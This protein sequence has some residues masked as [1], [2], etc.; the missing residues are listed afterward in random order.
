MTTIPLSNNASGPQLAAK[1][2]TSNSFALNP[3]DFIKMMITQLQNQDPLQPTSN[4]QLLSQMS[5]IGQMQSASSLQ[6]TLS[7]LAQ[8][9][10]IGAASSLIGKTVQGTDVNDNPLSGLV[11]S[12]K[13]ASSGISLELDNGQLLDLAKVTNISPG[14]ATTAKAAA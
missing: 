3:Q 2:A 1:G 14:P 8:Q 12:V 6:T 4:D 9:T 10:Q 7:G 11:T 5:Q 13:V